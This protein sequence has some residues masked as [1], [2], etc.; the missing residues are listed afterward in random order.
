M[1]RG[2]PVGLAGLAGW[3]GP[4]LVPGHS[5]GPRPGSRVHH[6]QQPREEPVE[7]CVRH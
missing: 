2:G 7:V 1:F 4:F 5:A 3:P 6:A